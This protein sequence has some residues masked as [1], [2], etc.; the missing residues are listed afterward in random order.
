MYGLGGEK[1]GNHLSQ[2]R[3]GAD[4]LSLLYLKTAGESND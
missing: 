4:F 2:G 3:K 1:V